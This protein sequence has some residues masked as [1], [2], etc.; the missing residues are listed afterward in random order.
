VLENSGIAYAHPRCCIRFTK[1]GRIMCDAKTLFAF[2][3]ELL[4]EAPL[5]DQVVFFKK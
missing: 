1:H 4:F 2:K 5:R 3:Q